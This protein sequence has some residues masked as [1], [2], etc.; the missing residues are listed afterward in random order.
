MRVVIFDELRGDT[1]HSFEVFLEGFLAHLSAAE[2]PFEVIRPGWRVPGTRPQLIHSLL[3]AVTRQLIYPIWARKRFS[4]DA[5]HF[6][7]SGGL[8]QMLWICPAGYRTVVFCHDT[9]PFLAATFP[10]ELGHRLDYGGR[11]RA[12][13]L[14]L[15]QAGAFRRAD[16]IVA[17]SHR[18]RADL[19]RIARVAPE[20]VVV[21]PHRIDSTKF[22]PGDKCAARI[23]LGWPPD[24]PI[25]LAVISAE[26]RKNLG[27]LLRG[28][29]SLSAREPDARLAIVGELS[30][31]QLR[32]CERLRASGR[33]ILLRGISVEKLAS[34]YRAADCLSHLSFYE[35]F[36]YPL[37]EAMACG[38]PIVC[39]ARGATPEIVGESAE[40]VES[41]EPDAVAAALERVVLDASRQNELGAMGLSRAQTFFAERP[42]A[43]VLRRLWQ[44]DV[45]PKQGPAPAPESGYRL[46][47]AAGEEPNP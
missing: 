17:P 46:V 36:G 13:Y 45:L 38:C 7:V 3:A 24:A 8:V 5:I 40:Y 21:I 19:I 44:S 41:F 31:S 37:V 28:F 9:F 20:R 1:P 6:L 29:E 47:V 15:V 35:G 18:T 16:L 12:R 23:E 39:A 32:R 22:F 2:L 25:V 43:E 14:T 10:D 30:A 42:Y 26:R 27:S 11:L 34:C 33:L 4:S